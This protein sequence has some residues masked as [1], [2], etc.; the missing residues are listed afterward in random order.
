MA[1]EP[2]VVDASALAAIL[3]GE[4]RAAAVAS[5]LDDAV[6][7]APTLLRYEIASVCLKKLKLYPK[8]QG[9][10]LKALALL[11]EVDLRE[12][13]VALDEVVALARREN[14]TA[15]DAAYLWLARSLDLELVTLDKRLA[16]AST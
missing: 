9:V 13:E 6:L 7:F 10:I 12:V 14:L 1:I 5:R 15:Y 8:R 2:K 4:P 16:R 11:D 3:F